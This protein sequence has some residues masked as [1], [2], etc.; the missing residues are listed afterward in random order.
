M[1]EFEIGKEQIENLKAVAAVTKALSEDKEL[2]KKI[3]NVFKQVAE[4]KEKELVERVTNLLAEKVKDVSTEQMKASFNFWY[5]CYFPPE[6]ISPL[7]H[8]LRTQPL[9]PVPNYL[10]YHY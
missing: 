4:E 9:P 6:A 7:W 8:T 2:A 1:P 10:W 3:A 5:L